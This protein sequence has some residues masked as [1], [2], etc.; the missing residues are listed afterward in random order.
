MT[1]PPQSRRSDDTS[2]RLPPH[3]LEA[4]AG[5]LGCI[6]LSPR[7]ALVEAR[8]VFGVTQP[9]YDLKHQLIF[10]TFC[11]MADD[12]VA[13]DV[14]TVQQRLKDVQKLD[15]AGGIAYLAG[16]PDVVP[17]A[18]NVSFYLSIVREKHILRTFIREN[19]QAIADSY[20]WEG[21]VEHLVTK[22][23][24]RFTEIERQL[25]AQSSV[26]PSHVKTVDMF[27]DEVWDAFFG[28]GADVNTGGRELPFGF[29][30]RLR[31]GEMTYLVGESGMGKSTLWSWIMVNLFPQG[32]KAFVANMEVKKRDTIKKAICQIL[33]RNRL[34][35][36]AEEHALLKKC[37]A[38]L[39]TRCVMFDFLGIVPWRELL[40]SMKRARQELGCD[41]FFV[42]SV[43]R[44]GVA[45]DDIAEADECA[46]NFGDFATS[47]DCHLL[48]VNHLNKSDGDI[49]KRSRGTQSW[50]DNTHN[51]ISVQRNQKKAEQIGEIFANK[52]AGLF[53]THAEFQAKL[54]ALNPDWDGRFVLHK[55][56]MDGTQQ[57]GSAMLWFDFFSGQYRDDYHQPSGVNLLAR[58]QHN[59]K[60]KEK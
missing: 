9:F 41:T 32:A 35:D 50:S 25:A 10:D 43:M 45:S 60:Q 53:K 11:R 16:L 37:M 6:F 27:A 21:Q 20:A 44:I 48:L 47:H 42:D 52:K 59:Q 36:T 34:G 31:N 58:W 38:Y 28:S 39:Q 30:L 23:A 46:K 54:D 3:S 49:K 14:I 24:A 55:Q 17:S 7:E 22:Q 15:Q 51:M 26:T 19:Q 2:D 18:V 5:V 57:N 40:E 13:I 1:R 4:E 8:K 29:P 33:G 12:G 56:R